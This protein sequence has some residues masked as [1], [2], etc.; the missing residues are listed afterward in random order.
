MVYINDQGKSVL[1]NQKE[2][3]DALTHHKDVVRY[4]PKSLDQ[5][6]AK[7]ID[8]LSTTISK[9][10]KSQAVQEEEQEDGSIKETM[11]S[12]ALDLINKLKGGKKEA[13]NTLK[14][15]KT[16]IKDRYKNEN[17]DLITWFIVS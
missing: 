9:W 3:L 4:V 10:L 13:V 11:G 7:E 12:S 1:S 17:Y 14:E 16:G 15:S 6:D 5:G 2:I 8:Q